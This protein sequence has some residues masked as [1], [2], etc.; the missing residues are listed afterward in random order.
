MIDIHIVPKISIGFPVFNGEKLIK[1]ALD[2]LLNQ[3]F[4][5]F[6]LI[7]SDNAS[8]DETQEI[9]KR[10]AAKDTRIKYVRQLT[11]ISGS[12]NFKFVL[13]EALGE[14]FMWAACDDTRSPNFIE[15]NQEFLSKHTEFVAST[16]PNG[17][18]GKSL[19]QQKLV[20]FALNGDMFE[21]FINF[22]KHCWV[23]HGIFYSLVR[24]DVLRGCDVIGQSYTAADWS[25]ILYLASKG[26]INR[27]TEGRTIFGV[28]GVS[29]GSNIYKAF[30]HD[31]IELILPFYRLTKYVLG[32]TKDFTLK[33]KLQIIRILIGLNIRADY[34][35][36]Y[37]WLYS[38][39][40]KYLRHLVRKD[41]YRNHKL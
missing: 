9:C 16:S 14:Y 15:V 25:I 40:C 31:I 36:T 22:F 18:E 17:F 10:Y 13:D 34:E 21:R 30:R 2:S 12:A 37:G 28:H 41:S 8:T 1:S 32:L 5:D 23:S 7:I 38:I 35:R 6:E 29:G 11:H 39:Y 19:D 4:K 3:T 24:T 26:N 20:N 27:T 33:R